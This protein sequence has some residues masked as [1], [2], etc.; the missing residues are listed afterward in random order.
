MLWLKAVC[1]SAPIDVKALKAKLWDKLP[2][3]FDPLSIDQRLYRNNQLQPVGL[4]HVDAN[5]EI[6]E[7][8][9]S[10]I[11][12]IRATILDAP[13][14]EK[15]DVDTLVSNLSISREEV[16][17]VFE[18]LGSL[19]QFYSSKSTEPNS[20]VVVSIGLQGDDAYDEYLGYTDVD[21]L[22]ERFYE[23]RDPA[24]S[25]NA[26]W[27]ALSIASFSEYPVVPVDSVPTIR[28]NTAFVLMAIDDEVPELEDV[29]MAIR[30]TCDGFGITAYRANDIEH[31]DRITDRILEEIR[32]CEYLIADLSLER[33]NV[34]YEI[35]Y[36]HAI[37]KK[38]ILFRRRETKVH[39]DLS[40]HNVPPYK[41]ATELKAL[42]KARFEAILGRIVA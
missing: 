4:W 21:D 22:L 5:R 26:S 9:D 20:S 29:F 37:H 16:S 34:Y 13:G 39:F 35:G 40:V 25:A 7:Q 38:P 8:I 27:P 41:N 14:I 12:H 24:A 28:P 32:T 10:V 6:F 11:S 1:N 17:R 42:L 23:S 15:V 18:M 30:D 3:G 31:Q 19:G 2:D 36:A 33:P